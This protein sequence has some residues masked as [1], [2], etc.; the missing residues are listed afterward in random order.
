MI[1]LLS[2]A[3]TVALG[4]T[5]MV[6]GPHED[7]E[8]LIAAG[9]IRQAILA[10]DTVYVVLSTNGDVDGVSTGLLREAESVAAMG[11]LGVPE[12]Q[13]VFLGY[14]DQ[15]LWDIFNATSPTQVFTS[16][17]GQTATYGNRGLGGKDFHRYRTGAAGP[18][19]R[20]T[21][22]GD[23]EAL[24]TTFQPDEVYTTS[25]FDN[26]GDHEGTARFLT[27]A[28]LTLKRQGVTLNTRIY[29]SIVWAPYANGGC[30]GDWPPAGSG[31]LPYPPFPAPQCVGPGTT[32]DWG[33]VL[34][35]PAPPEMQQ[36][37][38]DT[39]LK[40]ESLAAYPSQFN[41]FLSSFVRK[42]EFFWRYDLVGNLSGTATVTVSS[43]YLDANAPK[44]NAVDMFAD[45]S[46]EWMSL[47]GNGAWIQLTWASPVRVAQVNLSDRIDPNDNVLAGTLSFSDGST[48]AVG[49]LDPVGKPMQVT[50]APKTVTWVK[51]TLDQVSGYTPG[52]SEME[53]LGAPASSTTNAPPHFLKTIVSSAGTLEA[54][55]TATLTV[56]A[57]D[58]DGDPISY[59]WS[60][61]GGS[62]SGNGASVVFTAPS[63][64][65]TTLV[66][67]TAQISDGRGG[68]AQTSQFIS[69]NPS[70]PRGLSISVSPGTAPAGKPVSG[71]VVL[72]AAAPSGGVAVSLASSDVTVATVPASV[73]DPAG[74]TSATFPVTTRSVAAATTV[75]LTGTLGTTVQSTSLTV[76][77]PI[78]TGLVLSPASVVGG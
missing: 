75:T 14:G 35:F 40:W 49:A 72:S 27:E 25:Y 71:T 59:Q 66:T 50:F 42:D 20:A 38:S 10:G 18:Y 7:D 6:I 69:V 22:L 12:Q 78:P 8:A 26:H 68:T 73:T 9:R 51:F 41:D 17:A 57:F 64:S 36:P 32:L 61:D 54:G 56:Q 13:V 1:L 39:N 77:P 53:V 30:Y 3:P 63:V 76:T 2:L 4:R 62:I 46:H 47:D 28:L 55:Q 5:I 48:I 15:S 34:H 16:Q 43:E 37:T 65:Q 70:V 58:L 52:L 67:V 31:A 44:E 29:E 74:A 11:L 19:N 33:S 60:S 23:F 21:L 24:M 45:V